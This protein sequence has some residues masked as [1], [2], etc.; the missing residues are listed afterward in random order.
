MIDLLVKEAYRFAE[1]GEIYEA[2]TLLGT[3][4]IYGVKSVEI[5]D[6]REDVGIAYLKATSRPV[7]F[8]VVQYLGLH[9]F[10]IPS[11][12][13][14]HL[15]FIGLSPFARP[16]FEVKNPTYKKRGNHEVMFKVDDIW[17]YGIFQEEDTSFCFGQVISVNIGKLRV[18]PCF[19][20]AKIENLAR[21]RLKSIED[22]YLIWG[23]PND[24]F[25]LPE[26]YEATQQEQ[27]RLALAHYG[28]TPKE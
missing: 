24:F 21:K 15:E 14:D 4:H 5:A 10:I 11:I 22:D 28:I 27:T 6:L 12:K 23:L 16:F 18:I 20:N 1:K 2:H 3:L 17:V 8:G 7:R 13:E 19:A 26:E 9:M 25:M